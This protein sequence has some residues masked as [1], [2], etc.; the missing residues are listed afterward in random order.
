M[1]D[2]D[3]EQLCKPGIQQEV[4]SSNTRRVGEKK[5]KARWP[6]VHKETL[7]MHSLPIRGFKTS[8]AVI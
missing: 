6:R 3:D 4:V 2:D 8:R 1:I 5:R 7:T